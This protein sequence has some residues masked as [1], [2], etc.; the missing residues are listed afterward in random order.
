SVPNVE[1]GTPLAPPDTTG[2]ATGGMIVAWPT[3]QAASSAFMKLTVLSFAPV[4]NKILKVTR[5]F[6]TSNPDCFPTRA[7]L[8]RCAPL[9]TTVTVNTNLT[10]VLNADPTQQPCGLVPV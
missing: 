8:V 1:L 4:T 5:R 2:T 3:C 9:F 7:V 6:P 10:Y